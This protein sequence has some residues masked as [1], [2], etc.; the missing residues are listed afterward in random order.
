MTSPE[1]CLSYADATPVAVAS[2]KRGNQMHQHG[3]K[4]KWAGRQ[5]GNERSES[6]YELIAG[7]I[8]SDFAATVLFA[9]LGLLLSLAVLHAIPTS[10]EAFNQLMA[11]S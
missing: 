7:S 4:I 6:G 10:A 3:S 9:L 11:G 1:R 8:D 2:E 5:A